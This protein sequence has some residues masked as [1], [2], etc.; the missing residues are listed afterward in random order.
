MQHSV[1]AIFAIEYLLKYESIFERA[2]ACE[3]GDPRVLFAEKT[4]VRKS[5]DT[6]PLTMCCPYRSDL[7]LF[8]ILFFDRFHRCVGTFALKITFF[9]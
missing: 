4:E 8:F 2:S 9:Y 5:R 7:L 6:V 3:P 1:E